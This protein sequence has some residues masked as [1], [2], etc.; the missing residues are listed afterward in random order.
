MRRRRGLGRP[1]RGSAQAESH[2]RRDRRTGR[3]LAEKEIAATDA[4]CLAADT[5]EVSFEPWGA[6]HT[7]RSDDAFTVE[8]S[9]PGSGVAEVAYSPGWIKVCAWMDDGGEVAEMTAWNKAGE[10]LRL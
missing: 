2:R 6:A 4:E 8:I 9:G 7:L 3:Q 10:R 1:G 5:C